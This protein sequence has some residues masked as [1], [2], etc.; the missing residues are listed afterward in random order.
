MP[1]QHNHDSIFQHSH[2]KQRCDKCIIME[3]R[4]Y[5]SPRP[6][7]VLLM[8]KLFYRVVAADAV[9]AA[10]AVV[11]SPDNR[12]SINLAVYAV[13]L[14]STVDSAV[15]TVELV[16]VNVIVGDTAVWFD[17]VIFLK[18]AH[19]RPLFFIFVFSIVQ[20]VDQILPMSGFKLRISGVRSDRSTN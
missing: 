3:I 6:L 17:T 9:F 16:A 18:M 10:D 7:T 14:V 15:L 2:R 8:R 4:I 20:L 5:S 11:A 13:A 12:A 19:S 1:R